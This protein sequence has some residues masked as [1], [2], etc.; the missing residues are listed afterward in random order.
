MSQIISMTKKS[1]V[2]LRDQMPNSDRPLAQPPTRI[3]RLVL[4]LVLLIAGFWGGLGS[5]AALAPIQSAVVAMGSFKVWGDL[6]EVQHLE[7]GLIREIRVREGDH[8][9]KGQIL[10]VLADT[11]SSA[12]E[13]I[14]A[15]QMIGLLAMELRLQAEY[16]NDDEFVLPADLQAMVTGNP[17]FEELVATQQ[18]LFHSNDEM[19]RGQAAILRERMAEQKEQLAG[20]A[21][22][23]AAL[24]SR[25]A[26]IQDELA[27]L[28]QLYDRGLI[29]KSRYTARREAEV[30]IM[31]DADYVAS[32]IDGVRQRVAETEERILQIRRDRIMRI[33]EERQNVKQ[34]IFELRQRIVANDDI[35]ERR[36][37]RAP[38]AG[39]IIDLQFTSPGE[40]IQDGEKIL[41]IVPDDA[42]YVVEGRV[43]PEDVDQVAEGNAARVR[44][45]AYNF[46][47]TP[48]VEGV[49]THVSADSLTD[50]STGLTYYEV[51]IEIPDEMLATLP[52]VDVLPGMPAQ[53]M[54]ATGEQ[55]VADYL[56]NPV[57]GGFETALRESD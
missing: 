17:E 36:L 35:K 15:N 47:T 2:A 26:F 19:W 8:V 13:R 23:R 40:V 9:D 7:G 33:S 53:I 43:R 32:Q 54:I 11:V 52:N 37:I 27:D 42:V 5:W 25:L 45:T 41:Q 44:L 39:R 16:A 24:G 12:Q 31:G 38:L 51:N 56:L 28:K 10:V 29:T 20:L 3:G 50:K 22:R 46:R 6:P 57:I 14:L 21:A 48:A 18:E 30:S 34:Q 4:I 49:V 1:D 55:T